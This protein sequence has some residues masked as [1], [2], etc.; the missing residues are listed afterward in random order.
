MDRF[1]TAL[2]LAIALATPAVAQTRE[3]WGAVGD[4]VI[5]IDGAVGDGCLMQ[6]DFEDGIRIEFGYVPAQNGGYFAALNAEWTNIEPGSRGIVKFITEEAK[7][8][9]DVEMIEQDGRLGGWAFFNN[10][11]LTTEVAARRTLTVIGP[12]GGTFDVDLT[13][14]S[15][16]ITALKECQFEQN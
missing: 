7:F 8:A 12:A 3:H 15:R 14:T 4:W 10:P 16:A 6:K 11:A 1:L 13:G 5:L 9:G 2:G